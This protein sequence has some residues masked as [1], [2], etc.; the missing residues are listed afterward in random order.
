MKKLKD[1]TL[2][3]KVAHLLFSY[4]LTLQTTN[5]LSLSELLFGH[6][7]RCH[8]DFVR[9]NLPAKICQCQ[10]RQKDTHDKHARDR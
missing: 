8:L 9:P 4:R 3:T 6:H 7:I 5:S 2:E 10:S 1:G